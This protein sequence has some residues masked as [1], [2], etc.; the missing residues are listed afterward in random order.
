MTRSL[1]NQI[2][3]PPICLAPPRYSQGLQPEFDFTAQYVV[4][5]DDL[6]LHYLATAVL[7]LDLNQSWGV[8]C[9]VRVRG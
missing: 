5:V 6:F 3:L 8:E 1:Y 9:Q 2:P 7:R 4:G